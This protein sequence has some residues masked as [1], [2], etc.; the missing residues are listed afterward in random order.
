MLCRGGLAGLLLRGGARV[1]LWISGGVR[2]VGKWGS[3]GSGFGSEG[4]DG[5]SSRWSRCERTADGE[6]RDWDWG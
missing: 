2:G 4:E 5:R 3:S 6:E 1:S